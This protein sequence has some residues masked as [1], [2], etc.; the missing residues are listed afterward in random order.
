MTAQ[1]SGT[2]SGAQ[3][4]QQVSDTEYDLISLVYHALQSADTYQI[5]ED[6]AKESGN[7]EL[8]QLVSE[9]REQNMMIAQRAREMLKKQIAGK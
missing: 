5:Y 1:T 7:T 3:T 2:Q 6:D 9:A 8:Q 4:S